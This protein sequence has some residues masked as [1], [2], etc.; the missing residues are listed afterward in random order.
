MS[1]SATEKKRWS[2]AAASGPGE[3]AVPTFW[4]LRAFPQDG[5]W[6][7]ALEAG[8]GSDRGGLGFTW[9]ILFRGRGP[10]SAKRALLLL[11]EAC[12]GG[13]AVPEV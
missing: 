11:G 7:V 9:I 1:T 4:K 2:W 8:P 3:D 6:R 10:Q 12:W 13:G 5:A